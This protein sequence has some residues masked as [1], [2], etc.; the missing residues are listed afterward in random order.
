MILVLGV[1]GVSH[2]FSPVYAL[3]L[4]SGSANIEFPLGSE[5]TERQF[6]LADAGSVSLRADGGP[7][8]ACDWSLTIF[9]TSADNCPNVARGNALVEVRIGPSWQMKLKQCSVEPQAAMC[10]CQTWFSKRRTTQTGA[11]SCH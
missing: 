1:S 2:I 11:I 4:R 6:A 5:P 8:H 7:I 9:Q 3:A 10:H